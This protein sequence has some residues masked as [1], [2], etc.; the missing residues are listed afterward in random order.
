MREVVEKDRTIA[1]VAA[2]YG[3]V[4]QT[5]GNWVAR[6]KKDHA[7]DQEEARMAESSE[8]AR[9]RGGEQRGCVRRMSS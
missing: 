8:I 4:S 1:S 9:S 5:M 7:T 3:L 2:S 6:Y